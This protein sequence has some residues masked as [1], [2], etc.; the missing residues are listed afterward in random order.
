[1]NITDL[2]NS[3]DNVMAS[4]NF[5]FPLIPPKLIQCG[6]IARPGVSAIRMTQN[7][8]KDLAAAGFPIE[9]NTDGTPNMTVSFVFNACAKGPIDEF[10]KNGVVQTPVQI[11]EATITIPG[12]LT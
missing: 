8:L 12:I 1:M 6:V 5:T 4:V 7:I 11:G 2:L 9:E 10:T 3:I